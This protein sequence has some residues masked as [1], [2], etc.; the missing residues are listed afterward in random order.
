MF[1]LFVYCVYKFNILPD[2]NANNETKQEADKMVKLYLE[3]LCAPGEMIGL[4]AAMASTE[5]Y[6]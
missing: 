2:D 4:K 5:P 3:S 1:Y 6:S